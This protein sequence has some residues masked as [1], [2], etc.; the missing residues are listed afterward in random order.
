LDKAE[1]PGRQAYDHLKQYF[2]DRKRQFPS[3]RTVIGTILPR[4]NAPN[5]EIFEPG[6]LITSALLR[7]AAATHEPWLD[8]LA[9]P[10][11][12]EKSSVG[13]WQRVKTLSRLGAPE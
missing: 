10:A 2:L 1:Q 5:P 3:L 4:T 11:E 6:R 8:A 13:R 9:N 12:D 7:Q